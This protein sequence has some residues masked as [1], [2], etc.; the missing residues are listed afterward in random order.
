VRAAESSWKKGGQISPGPVGQGVGGGGGGAAAC[1][2]L[3]RGGAR[4]R[5]AGPGPGRRGPLRAAATGNPYLG[6][7]RHAGRLVVPPPAHRAPAAWLPPLG[8]RPR[9]AAAARGSGGL[10]VLLAA[11]RG[12][13]RPWCRRPVVVHRGGSGELC[14]DRPRGGLQGRGPE[15]AGQVAGVAG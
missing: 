5:V 14:R 3:G 9:G 10:G 11:G 15:P 12:R 8:Q 4:P 7:G 2:R 1:P 13:L 6:R